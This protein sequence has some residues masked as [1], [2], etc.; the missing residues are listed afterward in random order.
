M[1][2]LLR[3]PVC[4]LACLLSLFVVAAQEPEKPEPEGAEPVRGSLVED[5]AARKLIEAGDARFDVDEFAKALEVWQSVVERYPRS[6]VRFDAH[7]RL[8]N[9]LLERERAYDRARTHFEP[10][11]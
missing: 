1:M 10:A 7:M 11:A 4:V 2:R 8:G 9:Y 3:I 5:R 6:K